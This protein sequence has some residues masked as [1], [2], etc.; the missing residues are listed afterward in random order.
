VAEKHGV[1]E[2][3]VSLAWL[4]DRGLAAIP[5]ATD[6]AHVRDNWRS[7]DLALDD[8]DHE[9]IAGIDRRDRRVDPDWAPW[10]A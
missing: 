2:A 8:E 4:R 1:S 9:R 5:K 7:L 10:N 3:R 6:P